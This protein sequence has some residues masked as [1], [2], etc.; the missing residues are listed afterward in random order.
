MSRLSAHIK[1]LRTVIV[2]FEYYWLSIPFMWQMACY[3]EI[4]A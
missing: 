4:K 2:N 1:K 3:S